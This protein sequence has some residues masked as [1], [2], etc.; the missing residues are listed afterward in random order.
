[1]L[2]NRRTPQQ[3][4]AN[5]TQENKVRRGIWATIFPTTNTFSWVGIDF[6]ARSRLPE[7]QPRQVLRQHPIIVPFRASP[8]GLVHSTVRHTF[9]RIICKLDWPRD[10]AR[11]PRFL[12]T[13]KPWEKKHVWA[14]WWIPKRSYKKLMYHAACKVEFQ[15][16]KRLYSQLTFFNFL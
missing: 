1:M 11:F 14:S 12:L 8:L 5:S 15:P 9:S 4:K 7:P 3:P 10:P 16:F 6:I 2:W 13:W